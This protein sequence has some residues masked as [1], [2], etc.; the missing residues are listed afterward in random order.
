MI[1][2]ADDASLFLRTLSVFWLLLALLLFAML[3]LLTLSLLLL[4]LLLLLFW[5]LGRQKSYCWTFIG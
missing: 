3:K 4:L 2:P 1:L 5:L